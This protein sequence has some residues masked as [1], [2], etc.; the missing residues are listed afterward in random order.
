MRALC[1]ACQR[2]QPVDWKPGDFCVHCGQAVRREVRCFWCVKWTPAGKFCR[3]CGGAVVDERLFGAARMLKDAGT[4]R[5][6]IPRMLT[7]LD[8]EQ[9]EMFSRIYQQHAV[10]LA[11][12]VDQIEWLQRFLSSSHW[13]SELEDE[14]LPQLPWPEQRLKA[15]G[16]ESFFAGAELQTA[17]RIYETTPFLVTR[18]LAALAMVLLGD[19][20]VSADALAALSSPDSRLRQEAALILG[21]WR[22][23]FGS[24][25]EPNRRVLLAEL[26]ACE[27]KPEAA[28]RIA[29]LTGKPDDQARLLVGSADRDTAFMAAWAAGD[30]DQLAAAVSRGEEL[31]QYV[32][33]LRLVRMRVLGPVAAVL[34]SMDADRQELLLRELLVRPKP[35]AELRNALFQILQSG[36]S[37]HAK[38]Y[39][40]MLLAE[41][42]PPEEIMQVARAAGGESRIYQALLQRAGLPPDAL[43]ELGR[44]LIEN[45]RFT[46]NQYGLKDVA[47]EGRM[48]A[49][50]VPR[51]FGASDDETR[52]ELLGFAEEQLMEYRD[53]AL[54]RFVVRVAFGPYSAEVH[55]TAWTCLNRWYQR[56]EVGSFGAMRITQESVERFFDSDREF[57]ETLTRFL[58][59]RDSLRELF[60]YDKLEKFLRYC[61]PDFVL[62]L[63]AE[64]APAKG[65]IRALAD[66]MADSSQNFMLRVESLGLLRH[67]MKARPLES[68]VKKVLE[69]GLGTDLD[70]HCQLA[71]GL[72][73]Y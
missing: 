42:C 59:Y 43:A 69:R 66:V 38:E 16:G 55:K 45:G 7:E 46:M 39:A 49:D 25:V 2:P 22:I 3:S 24:T 26:A 54:H 70:Y 47:K 71:L 36:E 27:A 19:S 20:S 40:G 29:M 21:H 15:L 65:L 5:F 44:F 4:D 28:V 64:E 53:E 52:C 33:A 34:A 13:A 67:L 61:D 9:V 18:W 12:H 35:V 31:Q 30:V 68:S 51:A 10:V 41:G 62:R 50:F 73:S 17:R 32:A 72:R 57:L 48:P 6:T 37:R 11:R 56:M 14:L 60:V 8:P 58:G 23:V 63:A 1:E